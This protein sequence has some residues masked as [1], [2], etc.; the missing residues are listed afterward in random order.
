VIV[1]LLLFISLPLQ[2]QVLAGNQLILYFILIAKIAMVILKHSKTCFNQM[3]L[4]RNA[5]IGVLAR[6]VLQISFFLLLTSRLVALVSCLIFSSLVP[7]LGFYHKYVIAWS[8]WTTIHPNYPPW[9]AATLNI[10]NELFLPTDKYGA[11]VPSLALT[12]LPLFILMLKV[13]VTFL[14]VRRE[15][16]HFGFLVSSIFVPIKHVNMSTKTFGALV[17]IFEIGDEESWELEEFCSGW[18]LQGK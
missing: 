9:Q 16:H 14:C 17:L 15:K 5:T 10:S 18:L 11:F 3:Q 7:D 4:E 12:L 8:N 13:G 2:G 6:I 1:L